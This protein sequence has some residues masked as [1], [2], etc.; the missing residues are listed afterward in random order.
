MQKLFYVSHNGKDLGPYTKD[1]I[2][3]RIQKKELYPSDYVYIEDKDDWV[4]LQDYLGIQVKKTEA[5]PQPP[6]QE[7]VVA[8][9]PPP[10]A[11]QVVHEAKS[12]P[13]IKHTKHTS[14]EIDSRESKQSASVRFS[15]GEAALSIHNEK[16]GVVKVSVVDSKKLGLEA[17]K[18]IEIKFKAG[19]AAQIHFDAPSDCQVG[20]SA[21]MNFRALDKYGNLDMNYEGQIKL[22]ADKKV[23]GLGAIHFKSG[24]AT[25]EIKWTKAESVEFKISPLTH[26]HLDCKKTHKLH[27]KAAPACRLEMESKSE[28]QVGE[29][30]V[31][32][33]KAVD[34]WGNLDTNFSETI[35]I[36]L[37]GA[38]DQKAEVKMVQGKGSVRV[39]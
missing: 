14:N 23:D 15:H 20:T 1:D 29:D 5:R 11:K 3:K 36:Q 18:E 2:E 28:A 25:H 32:H 34:Q 33:V 27:F 21:K 16:V 6:K 35:T 38:L 8:I 10:V 9:T 19:P 30:V 17:S 39:S 13:E 31:M 24:V 37:S 12:T 4:M 22:E 7:R 26:N